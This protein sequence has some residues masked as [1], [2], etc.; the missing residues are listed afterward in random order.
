VSHV[1]PDVLALRALGE[2][3]G[4]AA[5][6]A[7]LS[8]CAYC[9]AELDQL[10]KVVGAA[11][12]GNHVDQLQ[13]PPARVWDRITEELGPEARLGADP[14]VTPEPGLSPVPG[15]AARIPGGRHVAGPVPRARRVPWWRRRVA[16]GVVGLLIGFGAALGVR[17]LVSPP[18][19]AVVASIALRP[20]PQFPQWKDARGTAVM[21]RGASGKL[22]SVKLQAPSR[23]GFYEVW[24]LARDGVSMISLGDLN[25]DHTGLFTMPPGVNLANYSRID[26]SLQPFNGSTLHSRDSVVRGSLP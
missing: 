11:R 18:G 12:H 16:V 23:T 22:L 24:L 4:T 19:P 1:D 3:A 9:R 5:D 10:S 6:D 17:Q 8:G 25:S 7:H 15:Q 21:E 14:P 26:V 2:D 20:L 13:A